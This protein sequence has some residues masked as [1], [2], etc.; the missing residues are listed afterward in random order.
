MNGFWLGFYQVCE[1]LLI[2]F[3]VAFILVIAYCVTTVLNLKNS[4]T[5]NAKRLYQPPLN[6]AKALAAAGKGV[7]LQEKVRV[8][9]IIGGVKT[10]AG[11]VGET[12]SQVGTAAK[13][14][15]PEEL[16]AAFT[17]VQSTARFASTILNLFRAAPKQTP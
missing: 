13:T 1:W 9:H 6:S 17:N 5:R 14:V 16:K 3:G 11:D 2:L 8:L 4:A 15:H 12:A 10:M 7:V